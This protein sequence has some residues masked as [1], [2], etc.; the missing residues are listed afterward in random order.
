MYLHCEIAIELDRFYQYIPIYLAE[1]Y[2]NY[3]MKL[4]FYCKPY[5][6]TINTIL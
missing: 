2:Q 6:A 4:S 5:H 1:N 3:I